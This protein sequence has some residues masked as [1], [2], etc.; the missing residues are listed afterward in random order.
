MKA[1]ESRKCFVNH[2]GIK[3]QNRKTERK[4]KRG[5]K[6]KCS[7][8]GNH[9][10]KQN[11]MKTK[12]PGPAWKQEMTNGKS[13]RKI[14]D[15]IF[16][17]KQEESRGFQTVSSNSERLARLQEF[18]DREAGKME[19]VSQ[20]H[21]NSLD[22]PAED[23]K[24]KNLIKNKQKLLSIQ[25]DQEDDTKEINKMAKL[26]RLRPGQKKKVAPMFSDDF[27]DILADIEE[28][29]MSRAKGYSDKG[30]FKKFLMCESDSEESRSSV[31]SDDEEMGAQ[32]VTSVYYEKGLKN[33]DD[34]DDDFSDQDLDDG[35]E[36]IEEGNDD[37]AYESEESDEDSNIEKSDED[38]TGEVS[39]D[40]ESS[41]E[42]G[43]ERR[44]FFDTE[45]QESSRE[46][47]CDEEPIHDE[48]K[49]Y[50]LAFEGGSSVSKA[51]FLSNGML[52]DIDNYSSNSGDDTDLEGFIVSD[53]F[54]EHESTDEDIL[55]TSEVKLS[56][57]IK[58]LKTS[59]KKRRRLTVN[60]S[61]DTCN[62]D[63]ESEL[64]PDS[65]CIA[66]FGEGTVVTNG[67]N[68]L[69]AG[70]LL[71]IKGRLRVSSDT[72]NESDFSSPIKRRRVDL[73]LNGESLQLGRTETGPSALSVCG[74]GSL[75]QSVT[76]AGLEQGKE[77]KKKTKCNLST[78]ENKENVG[79]AEN[80][81]IF[82]KNKQAKPKKQKK[83][84]LKAEVCEIGNR[85]DLITSENE[86][87]NV[88]VENEIILIKNKKAK[89]KKK[90]KQ[91]L[92]T[93]IY[94]IGN[95]CNSITSETTE[96]DLLEAEN[97]V[98]LNNNKQA[99]SKKKKKQSL[100]TD[101]SEI[102]RQKTNGESMSLEHCDEENFAGEVSDEADGITEDIYG[103]LK[104]KEGNLIQDKKPEANGKYIPPALRKLLAM[105]VSEKKKEQLALLKRNL[106]GLINRLAES[107]LAGIVSQIEGLYQK[108][109]QNDMSDC[110]SQLLAESL[111]LP[112]LTPERL[113][114][115]HM[116]L[117]AVLSA[118]VGSQVG[119][120]ILTDFVVKLHE[121]M[122]E[123][124]KDVSC[125]EYDNIMLIVASLFNFRV[126]GAR[127]IYDILQ[128][129][130]DV[131]MEKEV[132]LIL[133]VLRTVGFSL[134]KE[135]PLALKTFITQIQCQ[136]SQHQ[137]EG[138]SNY[139]RISFMLEIIHSIKNNNPSK[140][141]NY[142]PSHVEHLKKVM[143]GLIHKGKNI[144]PLYVTLDD[145]LNSKS[146]GRWWIV[147]SAWSGGLKE[148]NLPPE[149]E[150][151]ETTRSACIQEEFSEQFKSKAAKLKLNRPPRINIMY[152]VTEGS[153]DYLDAFNKLLQLKLPS[154]QEQEIFN[155]I[156]LCCQK[157]KLYNEFYSYLSCR[158][159]K[160]N[161][162]FRRLLQF[163][164]WDK[165]EEIENCKPREAE[166]LAKYLVH[167]IGENGLNITILKSV[168]LLEAGP[169][170]IDF[171][172]IILKGLLLH[173]GGAE[174]VLE[175]FGKVS[176]QPELRFFVQ[177]L[178]VFIT[179][180]LIS[181][182]KKDKPAYKLLY[183]RSQ[184]VL[185]LLSSRGGVSM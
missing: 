1:K 32:K 5:K 118:N 117:I 127:L 77:T 94:E 18:V 2:L 93:D 61:S 162:K 124:P 134:R 20:K 108:H 35:L 74:T 184:D 121:K 45:A 66:E 165:F 153:E 143:K 40:E 47:S 44:E 73:S 159:C 88:K 173:P 19:K 72:E 110:L 135:D 4:L 10:S 89:S 79:K 115:E 179:K 57:Q 31:S 53:D 151:V 12:R 59:K 65:S 97:E 160:F 33:D 98:S 100:Q 120:H 34:D 42:E 182:K 136:A 76:K 60:R 137:A 176:G 103:R 164:V 168:P 27:G 48:T 83:Q 181:K 102:D 170:M 70:S 141:P 130:A 11:G 123:S 146:Q 8:D 144:N 178:K 96:T 177:S 147:G 99:K 51:G 78:Y 113:I 46:E 111:V 9:D 30:S 17:Q 171:M 172:R 92:E 68:D 85:C 150:T 180:F 62:S 131:F 174:R 50:E 152:V 166:N 169:Q 26:L 64:K 56:K 104:D 125:K 154:N 38:I 106:K 107:N 126:V 37:D 29:S 86:E 145:I 21:S 129:L 175:I 109:S 49:E 63:D 149:R 90:K 69:R 156:L 80:E 67:E 139:T 91:S 28:G 41:D 7:N 43:R 116:L 87:T 14:Q 114:H 158:M 138:S 54:V 140:V 128:R 119:A 183:E 55:E 163:A 122:E 185:E 148:N 84:S 81:V 22:T 133:L 101:V 71:K 39:V 36:P 132:E 161:K 82:I 23:N 3:L 105:N 13:N 157:G 25:R 58:K 6:T 142:D 75:G 167:L 155:V 16:P 15:K 52:S 24:K 95:K 112:T